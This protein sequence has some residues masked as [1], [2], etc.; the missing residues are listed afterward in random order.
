[1]YNVHPDLIKKY[2]LPDWVR[3]CNSVNTYHPIVLK[4]A[5]EKRIDEREL[6]TVERVPVMTFSTLIKKHNVRGCR[7]LK[8][9]TEGHDVVI[10][11]SYLEC[12]T[13]GEFSIVPTIRFEANS[14]TPTNVV[15]DMIEK[16]KTFGYTSFKREGDNIVA[17]I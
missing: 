13:R 14:L 1:V 4:I 8:I 7:H 16:L 5:I 11:K 10:L 2:Q 12:V 17:E 3:G 9:D 6:F 15:D